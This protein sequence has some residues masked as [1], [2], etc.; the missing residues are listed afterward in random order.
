M[1]HVLG[2]WNTQ[3][4]LNGKFGFCRLAIWLSGFVWECLSE[5]V[6]KS[7]SSVGFLI[8]LSPLQGHH[9]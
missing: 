1:L 9:Y 6:T 2:G 8:Q 7:Y 4:A 3:D 5:F